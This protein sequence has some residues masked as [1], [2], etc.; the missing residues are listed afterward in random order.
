MLGMPV[1]INAKV[2]RI[3]IDASCLKHPITLQELEK[4]LAAITHNV[5][6]HYGDYEKIEI[7][8]QENDYDNLEEGYE[9]KVMQIIKEYTHHVILF[10]E[11]LTLEA[12]FQPA[13]I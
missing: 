12:T 9:K 10:S 4:K 2:D 13:L 3:T 6:R 11:D 5:R 7:F 8:F 1:T